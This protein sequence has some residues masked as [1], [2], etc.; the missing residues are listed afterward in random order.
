MTE[1]QM[2]QYLIAVKLSETLSPNIAMIY[3]LEAVD[4]YDGGILPLRKYAEFKS[5]LLPQRWIA[6]DNL[7]KYNLD[8]VPP[9]RYLDMMNVRYV[10]VA[11]IQDTRIGNVY[12]DRSVSLELAPGASAA[13]AR[14]PRTRVT[15]L[16]ILSSSQ[17]ARNLPDGTVRARGMAPG[18]ALAWGWGHRP[19]WPQ[20]SARGKSAT[21]AQISISLA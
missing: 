8:F 16:G 6:A 15:S 19:T 11:K 10:L 13:L 14:I 12:Y 4:G 7:L 20:S 17:G 3:G 1:E 21:P 5:L 18:Q 2:R 9:D